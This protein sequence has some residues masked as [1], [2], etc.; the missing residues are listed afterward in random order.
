VQSAAWPYNLQVVLMVM[1]ELMIMV[2]EVTVYVHFVC[3]D[4]TIKSQ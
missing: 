1:A 4:V 2:V 3:A